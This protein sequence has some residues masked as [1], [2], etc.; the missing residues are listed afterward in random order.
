[1]SKTNIN[2]ITKLNL[3]NY[4]SWLSYDV[5]NTFYAGGILQLMALSWVLVKGQEYGLSY[6]EANNMFQ[7]T[8]S[9]SSIFM[10]IMLPILGSISDVLNERKRFLLV[11]TAIAIIST[12]FFSIASNIYVILVVFSISMIFYQ[13][14]QV[15]Y[16]SQLQGVVPP[17][18]EAQLSSIAVAIGYL[19]GGFVIVYAAFLSS[20]A[21]NA[22]PLEGPLTLGYFPELIYLIIGGFFVF[23]LPMILVN[24]IDWRSLSTISNDDA[25]NNTSSIKFKELIKSSFKELKDTFI[26]IKNENRGMLYYILACFIITDFANLFVLINA[27]YFRDGLNLDEDI[28]LNIS[29]LFGA[30]IVLFS[31][32]IGK[33]ADSYGAKRAFQVIGIIWTLSLL[34]AVFIDLPIAIGSFEYTLPINTVY[35]IAVLMG[36]AFSGIWISQRQMVLE[37]VPSEKEIGRYFGITK[38]SGKISSAFGPLIWAGLLIFGESILDFNLTNS[39]RVAIFGMAFFLVIGFLILHYKVPNKHQEFKKRKIDLLTALEYY[40]SN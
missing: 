2:N 26:S 35:I 18:R 15:F 5:A 23:S 37:L 32:F 11:F 31:Y 29:I 16:D 34:I 30:S 6:I 22:D 40:N 19:G 20:N 36:P 3:K 39:Y 9:V 21:P 27:A 4:L 38:F 28:V 10:A 1:M 24:E 12:Y 14:A 8:L 25:S 33:I 13:W 17:G 7:I